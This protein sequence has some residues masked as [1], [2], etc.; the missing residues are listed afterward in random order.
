M[1]DDFKAQGELHIDSNI[2]EITKEVQNLQNRLSFL[3]KQIKA[4]G[5]VSP[6]QMS[7]SML[8]DYVEKG[9]E[10]ESV[11]KRISE[12]EKKIGSQQSQKSQT[13]G[14]YKPQLTYAQ[15]AAGTGVS[16]SNENYSY[17]RAKK[18]AK[19]ASK[20]GIVLTE[21]QLEELY[22][23]VFYDKTAEDLV[24]E[25]NKTSTD[26]SGRL[27]RK[28]FKT[29]IAEDGTIVPSTYKD[30]SGTRHAT[31][32][33]RINSNR[34]KNMEDTLGVK[35]SRNKRG[36]LST[37]ANGASIF[38]LNE[39]FEDLGKQMDGM[40]AKGVN[41]EDYNFQKLD[42]FRK[43]IIE[44]IVESIAGSA[45]QELQQ[46]AKN[47]ILGVET[48]MIGSDYDP[49][50]PYKRSGQLYKALQARMGGKPTDF[51][52]GLMDEYKAKEERYDSRKMAREDRSAAQKNTQAQVQQDMAEKGISDFI[53]TEMRDF[54]AKS[55]KEGG[56]EGLQEA[57]N[58]VLGQ[59]RD[60]Q[61]GHIA[62]QE[63]GTTSLSAFSGISTGEGGV[64]TQKNYVYDEENSDKAIYTLDNIGEDAEKLSQETTESSS[65]ASKALLNYQS[66]LRTMIQQLQ[67]FQNS[68]GSVE[69][70]SQVGAVVQG[71]QRRLA[72]AA[73]PNEKTVQTNIEEAANRMANFL[74]EFKAQ[75]ISWKKYSEE[76][77]IPYEK[78][79]RDAVSQMDPAQQER[80]IRSHKANELA[81]KASSKYDTQIAEISSKLN[82]GNL[83]TQ[84]YTRLT[85]QLS[86]LQDK[87]IRA[88]VQAVF[89]VADRELGEIEQQIKSFAGTHMQG[90]QWDQFKT[91][92][93]NQMT[94]G[95]Q[96]ANSP[97]S[98]HE[99]IPTVMPSGGRL[100]AGGTY[101][102]KERYMLD[103]G[104]GQ[105][106]MAP[107]GTRDPAV[108][109]ERYQ[110]QLA[111]LTTTSEISAEKMA[112]AQQTVEEIQNKYGTKTTKSGTR[113]TW[114]SAKGFG[115]GGDE[116]GTD[117]RRYE[118]AQ[119]IL[120][121]GEDTSRQ[122]EWLK[123]AI[124]LLEDAL[125]RQKMA[126][127]GGETIIGEN[128]EVMFAP[129][130][131]S[132]QET[133]QIAKQTWGSQLVS[134]L[135]Q[136]MQNMEADTAQ[137]T[138][139]VETE[140]STMTDRVEAE[141]KAS[142]ADTKATNDA[143]E[144]EA[145]QPEIQAGDSGGSGGS[146]IPPADVS[147]GNYTFN[148]E[149]ANINVNNGK[150]GQPA[151]IDESQITWGGEPL[152]TPEERDRFNEQHKEAE[153]QQSATAIVKAL[154]PYLERLGNAT[155][156]EPEPTNS[157]NT[158][159]FSR[160]EFV[161]SGR[162]ERPK[163]SEQVIKEYVRY[164][165]QELKI[166]QEVADLET[167]ID[168]LRNTN[169][170]EYEGD[171]RSEIQLI[172]TQIAKRKELL[173]LI[174]EEAKYRG[175]DSEG[176]VLIGDNLLAG[177]YAQNLD[178]QIELT[179][180]RQGVRTADSATRD[181]ATA[182]KEADK[183]ITSYLAKYKQIKAE[184]DKLYALKQKENAL[185]ESQKGYYDAEIKAQQKI[186]TNLS[187]GFKIYNQTDG[188]LDG[189][190]LSEK[191]RTE[192]IRQQNLIDAQS[193]RSRAQID[194]KA[195]GLP[196]STANVQQKSAMTSYLNNYKQ[197]LQLQRNIARAQDVAD[198][199]SGARQKEYADLVNKYKEQLATIRAMAPIF[200]EQ[201]KTINGIKI[202]DEQITEL[203]QQ[204]QLLDQ[205]QA[206]QMQKINAQAKQQKGLI[207]Q[208][209]EGFKASFRN[210]VDYS[211]AYQVIGYMRQ[212][213]STTIQTT[214]DL[215]SAM[216][217]LQIASGETY[218]SI[219][220]MT[221]GFNELGKEIGRST[222][223]VATAADDWLRAGYAADEANQLVKAS[224]DLSTLGQI[225]SADATSYLISMLKGWK[226]EVEDIINVVDRLTAVDIKMYPFVGNTKVKL[227]LIAR[228][229]CK[230]LC[231]NIK[232]KNLSMTA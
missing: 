185:D 232:L 130:A 149:N 194:Q 25:K 122:E 26:S 190:L 189:I 87:R 81:T 93:A 170:T 173:A 106:I 120:R 186:I 162:G 85:Q 105:M 135:N 60:I 209:A 195:A 142:T 146:N 111:E 22:E 71:L 56:Q 181:Y 150:I 70:K 144:S 43:E 28:A 217:S 24:A 46:K 208:I 13:G 223:D 117:K 86:D 207:Q 3:D 110:K 184:E 11:L 7:D 176:N 138:S 226:L 172:E 16:D 15:H 104:Q 215:D 33:I 202:S 29:F 103:Y 212:M 41:R 83:D 137:M 6:D 80:L 37:S 229:F 96:S 18:L 84:E 66:M 65:E 200:D 148:I 100:M 168:N 211:A 5:K 227:H 89:G 197:Q 90:E 115:I 205:N 2:P 118:H 19:E 210:L 163:S 164:K 196:K 165:A 159:G 219:Y 23:S 127:V 121:S 101:T 123:Q 14:T 166:N 221:K 201:A 73:S 31:E 141:E 55:F 78:V 48:G 74:T 58:A 67:E 109:L 88:I 167:K 206:T 20:K 82:A 40:L 214:K 128:G 61:R 174:Q 178:R 228:K 156:S 179:A 231:Y 30:A 139:K 203:K 45:N 35:S 158:G 140:V 145:Q 52:A 59:G 180:A 134:I 224:M 57:V 39:I 129:T 69:Q 218:D 220:E 125:N 216:V 95:A 97:G 38:T 222:R 47:A 152:I 116:V 157:Y 8:T 171:I 77:G 161:S 151:Q 133:E 9:K 44:A 27:K 98:I 114:S 154:S 92:F 213:F 132:Q 54:I 72:R 42:F 102:P 51:E 53:Q 147:G 62:D 193:E 225:E 10:Y 119:K 79:V 113:V 183:S 199:S 99:R 49:D 32:S 143:I 230:H 192:L 34:L 204:Q 94:P 188:E 131:R 182:I 1:A 198:S 136:H 68:L 108:A 160:G 126:R 12:L 4:L 17:Q 187:E 177:S 50:A 75:D 175:K 76:T 64:I 63:K 91:L 191:Q 112:R 107:A 21:R 169:N 124:N 153:V 155:G 36:I